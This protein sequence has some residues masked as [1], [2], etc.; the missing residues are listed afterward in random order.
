MI[1]P[2][3]GESPPGMPSCSRPVHSSCTCFRFLIGFP[4]SS[5]VSC[6]APVVPLC[7]ACLSP[8]HSANSPYQKSLHT[9]P[10]SSIVRTVQ[11][12][13]VWPQRLSL[14]AFGLFRPSGFIS[15]AQS[16]KASPSAPLS[17]ALSSLLWLRNIS[18]L[19]FHWLL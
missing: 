10:F 11:T 8:K 4:T 5:T 13:Q 19:A 1:T 6:L 15:Q 7:G 17:S 12:H 18:K 2:I 14:P 3:M 16:Q 9:V